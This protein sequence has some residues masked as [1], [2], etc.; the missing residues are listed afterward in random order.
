M[1]RVSPASAGGRIRQDTTAYWRE[2]GDRPDDVEVVPIY[3]VNVR[4]F[5]GQWARAAHAS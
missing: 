2:I 3:M 1:A 5:L 4:G